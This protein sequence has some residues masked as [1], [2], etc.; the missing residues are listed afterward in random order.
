MKRLR[1]PIAKMSMKKIRMRIV[2]WRRA[3]APTT[4]YTTVLSPSIWLIVRKG[5]NTRKALMLASEVSPPPSM[6][7]NPETTQRKSS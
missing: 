6:P 4:D 7:I 2:S 1:P 3:T 5:L